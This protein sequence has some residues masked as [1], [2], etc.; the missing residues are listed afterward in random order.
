MKYEEGILDGDAMECLEKYGVRTDQNN[1]Q[2]IGCVKWVRVTLGNIYLEGIGRRLPT[3]EQHNKVGSLNRIWLGFGMR[4]FTI[5]NAGCTQRLN[6]A[7]R[8]V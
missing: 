7:A 6:P 1:R 3:K 4:T 5:K 8:E 2:I